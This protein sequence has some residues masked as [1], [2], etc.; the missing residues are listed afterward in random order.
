M[1]WS[2]RRIARCV[3]ISR[4]AVFT[5]STVCCT[6]LKK[7]FPPPYWTIYFF[8]ELSSTFSF[9]PNPRAAHPR[10]IQYVS[11]ITLQVYH[12]KTKRIHD[13]QG[14]IESVSLVSRLLLL[15]A[16]S[17]H[18][19]RTQWPRLTRRSS[20]RSLTGWIFT[21]VIH[22]FYQQEYKQIIRPSIS[23]RTLFSAA[24]RHP[25]HSRRHPQ[26]CD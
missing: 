20:T 26:H 5:S 8:F 11:T 6:I 16:S 18:I 21:F 7:Y 19:L 2:F 13:V 14:S 23:S 12:T 9:F 4:S 17:T 3:E 15:S 22:H 10:P 24:H 25:Q 1:R